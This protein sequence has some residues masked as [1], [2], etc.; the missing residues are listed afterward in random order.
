MSLLFFSSV[1]NGLMVVNVVVYG[2]IPNMF[3]KK[4][5]LNR[6]KITFNVLLQ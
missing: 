3:C 4:K 6:K 2:K 5:A 1:P